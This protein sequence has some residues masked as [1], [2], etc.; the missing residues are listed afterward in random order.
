ME[1]RSASIQVLGLVR[2]WQLIRQFGQYCPTDTATLQDDLYVIA[3]EFEDLEQQHMLQSGP[4]PRPD[5]SIQFLRGI[6]NRIRDCVKN[7]MNGGANGGQ[8]MLEAEEQQ[9]GQNWAITSDYLDRILNPSLP[10]TDTPQ[11]NPLNTQQANL[12]DWSIFCNAMDAVMKEPGDTLN[13]QTATQQQTAQTSVF[14]YL[15]DLARRYWPT[16]RECLNDLVNS[17]GNEQGD[18]GAIVSEFERI[19]KR[20]TTE[21]ASS[22]IRRFWPAIRDCVDRFVNGGTSSDDRTNL[23]QSAGMQ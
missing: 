13:M 18:P 6:W 15:G 23:Q 3:N 10:P 22:Q 4:D 9:V 11:E 21:V 2:I 19:W 7:I 16:A 5:A 1:E 17:N 20:Q 8:N 14:S 12:Q